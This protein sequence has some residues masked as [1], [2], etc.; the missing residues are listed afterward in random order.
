MLGTCKSPQKSAVWLLLFFILYKMKKPW[1]II[2]KDWIKEHYEKQFNQ[3]KKMFGDD[4]YLYQ[5]YTIYYLAVWE[6]ETGFVSMKLDFASIVDWIE[7]GILASK[8]V[9]K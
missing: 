9:K 6:C 2:S 1:L 8:H 4:W 3:L 5:Y 7:F